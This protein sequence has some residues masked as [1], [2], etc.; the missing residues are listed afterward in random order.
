MPFTVPQDSSGIVFVDQNGYRM[1]SMPL[2]P[3]IKAVE[4]MPRTQ[5]RSD[6]DV[7][8]PS[9]DFVTDRSNLRKLMRWIDGYAGRAFRID[10][11]LAGNG[12][13]LLS[14]WE[15]RAREQGLP[16]SYGFNFE[17][18]STT[19]AAG[20]EG[21]TSHHR[22]VKYVSLTEHLYRDIA[23][24]SIRQNFGGLSMI[25]RFE[26]DAFIPPVASPVKDI[27]FPDRLEVPEPSTTCSLAVPS[28]L[29]SADQRNPL[30]ILQGGAMVPQSS[31]I[32][33]KSSSQKSATKQKWAEIYP[34]LYLSQTPWLYK[35]IHRDGQF[36]TIR[37]TQLGSSELA[38]VAVRSKLRFQKLRLALQVIKNIV[39]KSGAQGRLSLVL[40]NRELVVFNRRSEA[41]CLPKDIMALFQE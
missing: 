11:Q 26:V 27:D 5:G 28:P 15:T 31:L 22:I 30:T 8:W 12:T 37:K 29:S 23:N 41:S 16:T 32:E 18:A 40:E 20:C 35:A 10:A 19:P 9:V 38:D 33:V 2:L 6:R 13:V 7:H 3:L 34:Q 24:C 1:K 17:E 25:V 14:R 21:T 4:F 39:I 36:Y